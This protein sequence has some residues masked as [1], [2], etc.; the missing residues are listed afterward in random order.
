MSYKHIENI[1]ER[2]VNMNDFIVCKKCE[3]KNHTDNNFCRHCGEKLKNTCK[4]WVKKKDNY[5]CGE[6]SCPGYS[7]FY[8]EKIKAQ[9]SFLQD[10][11]R[12]QLQ[13]GEEHRQ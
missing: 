5:D 11:N 2:G 13:I 8:Q 1:L 6:S 9:E 7:L 3:T 4:C 10:H 12:S